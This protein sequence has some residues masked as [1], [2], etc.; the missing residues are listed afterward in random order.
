MSSAPE[1]GAQQAPGY[2][3]VGVSLNSLIE[4]SLGI[5]MTFEGRVVQIN[6]DSFILREVKKVTPGGRVPVGDVS[7]SIRFPY[8]MI[9]SA[10]V[11]GQASPQDGEKPAEESQAP[12]VS[13]A[14]DERGGRAPHRQPGQPREHREQREQREQRDHRRRDGQSRIQEYGDYRRGVDPAAGRAHP[15]NMQYPREAGHR[16]QGPGAGAGGS[17][18]IPA[19][20]SRGPPGLGFQ[21]EAQRKPRARG[22][23]SMGKFED[24]AADDDAPVEEMLTS[25]NFEEEREKFQREQEMRIRF[26]AERDFLNPDAEVEKQAGVYNGAVSFFDRTGG[27]SRVGRRQ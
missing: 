14:M 26:Q 17:A 21:D 9:S 24:Q 20:T 5:G 10:T 7:A 13:Q 23:Q 16:A 11:L 4:L 8:A 6:L 15:R 2:T 3:P 19:T 12:S 22:F 27:P 25:V 18:A 1:A